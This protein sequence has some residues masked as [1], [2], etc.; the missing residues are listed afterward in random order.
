MKNKPTIENFVVGIAI[1][2]VIAGTLKWT[3]TLDKMQAWAVAHPVVTSHIV[4]GR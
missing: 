3:G 1:A 2:L 4:A